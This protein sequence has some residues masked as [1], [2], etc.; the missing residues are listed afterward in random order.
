MDLW[1]VLPVAIALVLIIE[2]LTPFLSPRRWRE[3]LVM[4]AQLDNS[5]IRYVGLGC[6]LTGLGLLYWVH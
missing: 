1:Q 2:G 5:A 4:A 6:M 3:M